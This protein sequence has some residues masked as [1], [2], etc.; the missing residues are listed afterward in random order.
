MKQQTPQ[1]YDASSGC[2][3]QTVLFQAPQVFP[4]APPQLGGPQSG[5][6]LDATHTPDAKSQVA[7]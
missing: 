5:G 2:P 4:P 1:S 3:V 6:Q 7:P